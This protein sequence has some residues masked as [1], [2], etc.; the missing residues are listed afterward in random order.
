MMMQPQA[1][2]QHGRGG[3]GLVVGIDRADRR[4]AL[5]AAGADIVLNDVSEFDIGLVL[6]QPWL[7][8]YDG[9][10]PVP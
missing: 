1:S 3:F 8:V 6:T 7:L 10:D 4:A 9:M 5:E 2:R